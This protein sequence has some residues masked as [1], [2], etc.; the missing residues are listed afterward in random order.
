[1]TILAAE[2]QTVADTSGLSATNATETEK[3]RMTTRECSVCKGKGII[4]RDTG[5]DDRDCCG[6]FRYPCWE[7]SEEEDADMPSV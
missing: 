5:C 7:C 4:E 2:T 3:W 1:M 6:P